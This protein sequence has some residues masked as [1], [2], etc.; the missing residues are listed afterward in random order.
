MTDTIYNPGDLIRAA[1]N[2]RMLDIDHRGMIRAGTLGIVTISNDGSRHL[3]AA[4]AGYGIAVVSAS[5]VE[6]ESPTATVAPPVTFEP[7]TLTPRVGMIARTPHGK[8]RID[9]VGDDYLI[10]DG[11]QFALHDCVVIDVGDWQVEP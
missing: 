1:I 4:F 7:V 3:Q 6:P 9:D 8:G 11:V 5:K 2:I 10:V